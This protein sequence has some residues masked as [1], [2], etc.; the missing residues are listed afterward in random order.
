M[1]R[2]LFIILLI[3]LPHHGVITVFGPDWIRFWKEGVLL[4]LGV[5]AICNMR[6][7][8]CK[9][10]TCHSELKQSGDEESISRTDRSFVKA[11]D[12]KGLRKY[13]PSLLSPSAFALLFLL[14]ATILVVIN[15]DLH[16]ALVA[17]RYL[18]LGYVVFLI[19]QYS[20][21]S[22]QCRGAR[23][24][25]SI[26]ISTLAHYFI[27]SLLVSV[28][29]GFWAQFLG[30]YEALTAWYSNTISSWVPGQ[31]IP[32]YH[33]SDG[34]I[35][36]QGT[37]SGP[38]E[39]SHLLVVGL[40]LLLFQKNSSALRLSRSSANWSIGTLAHYLILLLFVLAIYFSHSRAAMIGVVI[41]LI[42]KGI[43]QFREQ[44]LQQFKVIISSSIIGMIISIGIGSFFAPSLLHRA[45]T[46][47]HI[48]RP[49]EAIKTGFEHPFVGQ[50]G[51]WGPAARAKNLTESSN[52]N[53]PIAENVFA[54]Y[55]VQL[56]ILGLLC[57]LGFI[58]SLWRIF[59]YE[60]NVFLVTIFVLLNVLTHENHNIQYTY[61]L[62]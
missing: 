44:E 24:Q 31:T 33:E 58:W 19:I 61:F 21:F 59:D 46:S 14:W 26:S 27:L 29:F 4:V 43:E 8:I 7:A 28:L 15:P 30:G 2:I 45:G 20:I 17:F 62:Q 60:G 41:L 13:A 1:I 57:S 32:L 42:A 16:T 10:K 25:Q 39:F 6:H 53:A 22:I 55:F 11:Q 36:M 12:D 47:D 49:I 3:L 35:R 9:N 38:I 52:D 51:T 23:S 50:I 56:G 18:G 34:V 37:S 48:T 5:V 54:D 40:F